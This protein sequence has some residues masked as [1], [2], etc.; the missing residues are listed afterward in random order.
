[1][2]SLGNADAA[3]GNAYA[4]VVI[5]EAAA[6]DRVGDLLYHWQKNIRP[7]LTDYA[8]DAYFLSTPKGT[9]DFYQLW[10]MGKPESNSYDPDWRSW[11]MPTSNNPYIDKSEIEKAKKDLPEYLFQQEY[12][13]WFIDAP[14]GLIFDTWSESNV[15]EEADHIPGGGM[16]IWGVDDGYVGKIDKSTGYPTGDSHPRVILFGQLRRNGQ[17][18]VFDES[19]AL[20]ELEDAHIKAALNKNQE[21]EYAAVDSSAATLKGHFHANLIQTMNGSHPVEEGIKALRSALAP[22]HNGFRQIIVHP[23][24]KM[25]RYEMAKY[26]RDQN[27]RIIKKYDHAVDALRYLFH[28]LG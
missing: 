25:L 12:L 23:R 6:I 1:M 4:R 19:W 9:N 10:Q 5:D 21:P 24:C 2:W 18:A 20:Q 26:A 14:G 8:G 13:A 7:M 17:L 15:T 28:S 11:Q 22:D 27:G 3:L 16:L